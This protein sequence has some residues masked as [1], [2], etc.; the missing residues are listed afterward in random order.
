VKLL[1]E[2]TRRN[3]FDV[4]RQQENVLYFK[5]CCLIS[6]LFAA[7]FRLFHNFSFSVQII[8]FFLIYALKFK[9]T[10]QSTK[11]YRPVV[12]RTAHLLNLRVVNNITIG[13]GKVFPL[14]ASAGPWGSGRLRLRIFSTFGTMKVVRSSPLRTGRLHPQ[15][16]S[17]YSFL[18]H[19]S[20]GSFGK[21]PQRH[22][23]GSIPR[24]SN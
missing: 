6:V 7:K 19:S 2:N 9:Y 13:K 22:H 18:K 15:K 24:L 1:E 11:G 5:T 17:W 4:F 23:W 8:S 21:N 14:Q 16:F 12:C 20:V 3:S 10:C